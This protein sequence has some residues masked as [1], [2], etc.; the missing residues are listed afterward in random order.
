MSTS[1]N[2]TYFWLISIPESKM[3]TFFNTL[4][5]AVLIFIG[6]VALS[7]SAPAGGGGLSL[8]LTQAP[9]NFSDIGEEK[10]E[11]LLDMYNE[12]II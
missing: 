10:V 8:N 12:N 3:K 1:K 11:H 4:S 5:I 9:A 7:S 2:I 6:M